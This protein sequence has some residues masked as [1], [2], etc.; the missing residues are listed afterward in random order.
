VQIFLADPA[1]QDEG[2]LAWAWAVLDDEERARADQLM[3]AIDKQ[4]YVVAH[5]L[6]RG[7]LARHSGVGAAALRFFR[8][9]HGR[10]E[11][12][13]ATGAGAAPPVRF[14]L[15]HTRG[16]VG[17]AVTSSADIGLGV[18]FDIGFDLEEARLPAPL[19]VAPRYFSH[20]ERGALDALPAAE[21]DQRFYT[22]W[23]LKE[24]YIKGRGLG[25][26]IPLD[27]FSVAPTARGRASLAVSTEGPADRQTGWTLRWWRLAGHAMGLA[28]YAPSQHFRVTFSVDTRL[29]DLSDR[30][31]RH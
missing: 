21:Q 7:A 14:N 16:M 22:L 11:V 18:G 5:G 28:V 30:A 27:S 19:E 25:L 12:A 23:A 29:R 8:T 13:N 2:D 20:Q 24:A 15:A 1:R 26:A 10:P 9:P 3:H 4:T 17:C 31:Q 6:L